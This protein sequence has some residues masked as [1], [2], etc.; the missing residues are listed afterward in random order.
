MS[1][2][3]EH[4]YACEQKEDRVDASTGHRLDKF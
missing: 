4:G 2:R 1:A 3:P